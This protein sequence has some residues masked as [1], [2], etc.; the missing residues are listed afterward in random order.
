MKNLEI[1]HERAVEVLMDN[2]YNE[3][4]EVEEAKDFI[5]SEL[6][7]LREIDEKVEEVK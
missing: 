7:R 3:W 5:E 6:C 4:H 2:Q 1:L